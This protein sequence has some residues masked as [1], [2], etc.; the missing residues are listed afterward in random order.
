M[1]SSYFYLSCL[2]CSTAVAEPNG[3][4]FEVNL[5]MGAPP[6]YSSSDKSL[7]HFCAF[8]KLTSLVTSYTIMAASAFLK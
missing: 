5:M 3:S 4:A 1:N 6:D 7:T 2:N 8:S